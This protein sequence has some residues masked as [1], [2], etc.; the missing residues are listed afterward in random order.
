MKKN[1]L[2]DLEIYILSNNVMPTLSNKLTVAISASGKNGSQ[3]SAPYADRAENLGMRE[4][5]IVGCSSSNR[6]AEAEVGKSRYIALKGRTRKA[7]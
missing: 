5:Q 2:S 6:H 3:N 7:G 4:Y 1:K